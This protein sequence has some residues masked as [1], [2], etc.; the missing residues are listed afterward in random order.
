MTCASAGRLRTAR[1]AA[2]K[3]SGRYCS[4]VIAMQASG[5]EASVQSSRT[6]RASMTGSSLR[7][8]A[9]RLDRGGKGGID[10]RQR[11][12]ERVLAAARVAG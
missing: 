5:S 10:D 2:R 3:T 11:L 1:P 6:T 8:P 7:G 9:V 12:R 4:S